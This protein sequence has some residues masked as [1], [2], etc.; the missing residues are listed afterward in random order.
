MGDPLDSTAP[1]VRNVVKLLLPSER[2]GSDGMQT[3]GTTSNSS[4][5]ES[6]NA[7][8]LPMPRRVHA[9]RRCPYNRSKNVRN[10]FRL[11]KPLRGARSVIGYAN[12][13]GAR[14]TDWWAATTM[15][16]DGASG[17]DAKLLDLLAY[18]NASP[19]QRTRIN[20]TSV[21]DAKIPSTFT[22]CTRQY[23]IRTVFPTASTIFETMVGNDDKLRRHVRKRR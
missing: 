1:T 14:A 12:Y 15:N 9:S 20:G 7:N 19:P 23:R 6:K 13:H 4:T 11:P 8:H 21:K 3:F 16:Y 22:R 2:N 5:S 18:P 10:D 17:N